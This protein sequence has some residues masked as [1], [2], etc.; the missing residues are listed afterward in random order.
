MSFL[1][2]RI[3][4]FTIIVSYAFGNPI[5]NLTDGINNCAACEDNEC[6]YYNGYEYGDCN[7]YGY[8]YFNYDSNDEDDSNDYFEY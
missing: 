4:L 3:F 6:D 1:I 5:Q 7:D 2:F 8:D